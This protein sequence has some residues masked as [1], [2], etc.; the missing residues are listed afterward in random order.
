MDYNCNICNK[1]YASY[2]SLWIHNKKYHIDNF[3]QNSSIYPQNSS[4]YPQNSSILPQVKNKI[5]KLNCEICKKVFSRSDNL[6]RHQLKCN[7]NKFDNY[8]YELE[9]LKNEIKS[10][11]TNN[12]PITNIKVHGTMINGNNHDS[13]PKQIIYK[14]GTE[15]IDQISYDEVSTIFDNE[16]SS[17]IKLIELVNFNETK[18]E[19]HSFCSTALESPY[20]S[21]YN[22]DTNKIN[23]ERKRYFYED[24]ICKSIQ[25]HEIL[26][27]KFKNKFNSVKRKQIEDN[28]TNL[29]KIKENSFSSKIINE[30]GEKV[31]TFSSARLSKKSKDFL[32]NELIRNLNLLSYNKRDLIQ[33]TWSG[34]KYDNDSDEEFMAMLLDDPKTQEIIK[35]NKKQEIYN[36]SDSDSDEELPVLFPLKQNIK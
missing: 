28:I 6:K 16:I 24:V 13:G 10:L 20:L 25:N 15:N 3:P 2:Q 12:K 27:S 19:N 29:K 14:T 5:N 35:A 1:K 34:K 17:V 32:D 36:T 18:P 30:P 11:K 33:D 26:Y 7:K 21:F 8:D 4:I 22:T 9:L 23:K 31:K